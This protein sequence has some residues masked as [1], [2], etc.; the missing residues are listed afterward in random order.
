VQGR[1]ILIR[2][3]QDA[4]A[5]ERNFEDA[6]SSFSDTGDQQPVREMLAMMSRKA[7]SQH[8]RLRSRLNSFGSDNSTGKSMLAHMLGF[9]PTVAQLGHSAGE[10]NTQHLMIV[11]AAAAAEMAM[12]ESLAAAA[13]S[14]R[15]TETEQLARQLQQEE[16]GDYV[17]ASGMLRDSAVQS[18]HDLSAGPEQQQKSIDIIKRYLE[19]A[20][21]AERSFETQLRGFEKEGNNQQVR[22][23]FAQHAEETRAQHEILTRRIDEL[24]GSPSIAKSFM[25]HLFGMSPKAAQLGH[26][27]SERVTQNLMMAYAVENSE[28]A[29]YD[30]LIAV[31]EAAGDVQ[32][33]GIARN[34]REQEKETAAKVWGFI[35]P[36]AQASFDK[37]LAEEHAPARR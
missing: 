5:A 25:A 9:A 4:E 17:L 36:C 34:I 37:Q 11:M 28:V 23:L 30:A 1:D 19:D 33:A 3:L 27:E 14:A 2:Y 31:C 22:S 6:L 10:K 26:D 24:G 8:E 29:M 21:A 35:A 7:R 15:D 13:K 20:I 18:Y 12:Y 32:T 16:H